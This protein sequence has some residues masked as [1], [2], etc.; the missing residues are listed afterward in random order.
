MAINNYNN[1]IH[2][3]TKE[4]PRDI[5]FGKLQNI[6]NEIYERIE[7]MKDK[8]LQKRNKNRTDKEIN[9][10]LVTNTKI[11]PGKKKT[12]EPRFNIVKLKKKQNKH[13]ETLPIKGR[14]KRRTKYYKDQFQRK[15]KYQPTNNDFLFNRD[16]DSSM[17]DSPDNN[18]NN[19]VH[20]STST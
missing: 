2:S 12:K 19:N 9:E 16:S 3:T 17:D 18:T 20:P 11:T 14:D 1:V 5:H 6:H 8:T 7:T 10:N 15:K 13:Y 4:K